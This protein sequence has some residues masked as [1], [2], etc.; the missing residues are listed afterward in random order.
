MD[1]MWDPFRYKLGG[2]LLNGAMRE[3]RS[4]H[5][6]DERD[7]YALTRDF[8]TDGGEGRRPHSRPRSTAE[9]RN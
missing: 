6:S 7:K 8:A 4:H 3:F 9:C 5:G 2:R 1:P